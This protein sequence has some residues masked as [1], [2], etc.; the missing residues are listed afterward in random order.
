MVQG[1]PYVHWKIKDA[2]ELSEIDPVY[3]WGTVIESDKGP[4]DTPVF[5]TNAEQVKKIFNYNLEPFFV[6][7]GRSVVIV[8]AY[9]GQPQ[10]GSFDFTLDEDF[11]Y[12]YVDYD[13]YT[14]GDRGVKATVLV[15]NPNAEKPKPIISNK[16]YSFTSYNN[17]SKSVQYG[18]GVAQETGFVSGDYTQVIILENTADTPEQAFVGRNF[19]VKTDAI[20]DGNTATQLFEE[21]NATS[22]IDIYVTI[23]D[24]SGEVQV[25]FFEGRWR[26]CDDTGVVKHYY[27]E[28]TTSGSNDVVIKEAVPLPN[29]VGEILY[30]EEGAT[31]SNIL[32]SEPIATRK[33]EV[34][35]FTKSFNESDVEKTIVAKRANVPAGS[36]VIEL[37]TL[38]PGD[39]QVPISVQKD[40]RSGY[41]V[42]VKESEDFT[43]M[44]SGATTLDHISKRINERASNIRADLTSEGETV[45]K[46]FSSSLVTAVDAH[47]QPLPPGTEANIAEYTAAV[48]ARKLPV[49]AVFSKIPETIDD[50]EEYAFKLTETVTYLADGS[51]GSW[52]SKL[53]RILTKDRITAHK[54]ALDHLATIKL[55]GIFC[56]Y[57]EDD[58][59]KV[60]ADH[61]SADEAEGMNSSEVCKWRS[62][63]LGANSLDRTNDKGEEPGFKLIDKAVAFDNENIMFLGQG[64]IDDGYSPEANLQV[65]VDTNGHPLVDASGNI[66]YSSLLSDDDGALPNQLLPFQCTQ[67]VK[68]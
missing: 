67:Y 56:N 58:I 49:G 29:E 55:A 15:D 2:V 35:A 31:P 7:G 18:T 43:I 52:D 5:C 59:Q 30:Y 11:S 39:F 3:L 22:G 32:E 44:L 37:K 14:G 1:D 60:Y 20:V 51:N 10:Y 46:P 57:G 26:I 27:K 36:S 23:E 63:I 53:R 16:I 61:V 45:Q 13:Y 8:R 48:Q 38:Y 68:K 40:I 28:V 42:S 62:L 24:V 66:K 25:A 12:V 41:R 33:K 19:F 21:P 17:A 54:N 9:G 4:I 6:N 65:Q 64:L 47:G 34:K 50:T